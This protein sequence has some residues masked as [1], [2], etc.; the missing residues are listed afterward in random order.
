MPLEHNS[1]KCEFHINVKVESVSPRE[2]TGA[3]LSE[4]VTQPVC[5]GPKRIVLLCPSGGFAM[6]SRRNS[7]KLKLRRSF[8]E[9]L[10]SS[11]SKA[12]DLLWRNVRERRLAEQGGSRQAFTQTLDSAQQGGLCS[13]SLLAIGPPVVT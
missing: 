11:T 5:C 13:H 9:Q 1:P 7:A 10:R 8:S 2:R 12:W 4:T 3:F 6:T